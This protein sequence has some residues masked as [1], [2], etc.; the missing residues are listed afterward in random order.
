LEELISEYMQKTTMSKNCPYA[1]R[2]FS[3][4]NEEGQELC[5]QERK[6]AYAEQISA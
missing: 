1:M 6:Q 3:R 2:H 5:D 4:A